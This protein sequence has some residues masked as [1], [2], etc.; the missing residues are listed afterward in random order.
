LLARTPLRGV[1]AAIVL[2]AALAGG[3][4]QV[5][6]LYG[7]AAIGPDEGTANG[8]TTTLASIDVA[9]IEGR[10]GQ[11][12]RNDLLF[13][14]NGGGDGGDAY[15]V[16]LNV[17]ERYANVITRTYSGEPGGRNVKL[18]VDYALKK[19]GEGDVLATGKVTRI[20]SMD[21]FNQRFANDRATI[22]AENRL[23][24]EIATDIHLRLAAYF[25]TGKS[26][27]DETA[28]PDVD[29]LIP[30]SGNTI[31]DERENTYGAPEP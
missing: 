11:K 20:A 13:A 18:M 3:G 15:T 22:D 16:T 27:D 24:K 10:V 30:P 12:I 26:Y 4:C 9:P 17:R 31:F 23:A 8:M 28:E 6:P 7:T 14:L 21:Y 19:S 1:A 25:A 29:T 2:T 5:R